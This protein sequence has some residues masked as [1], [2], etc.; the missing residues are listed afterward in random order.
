MLACATGQHIKKAV[1]TCRKAGGDKQEYLVVTMT[2]C[3]ISSY[4]VGDAPGGEVAVVESV[5]INYSKMEMEYKAQKADGSLDS[6]KKVG[7]DL[8]INKKV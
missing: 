7:Y 2:D 6:P 8:K 5:A 1:L 3:L 4:N